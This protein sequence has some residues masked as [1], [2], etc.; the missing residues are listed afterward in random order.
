LNAVIANSDSPDTSLARAYV[1][2]SE[3][4]AVSSLDTVMQ[5]C[6]KAKIIAVKALITNP[7][8]KT[9]KS[10]L[11]ILSVALNNLGFVY[12]H[13]G[14]NSIAL[15]HYYK[16]LKIDKALGDKQG[17]SVGLLNIADIYEQQGDIPKAL[18]YHH[19]SLKTCE[20][21]GNKE[22]IAKN[23]NQLG[24][25]YQNQGDSPKAIEY[26]NKSLKISEATGNKANT[27]AS[28]VSLGSAYYIQGDTNKA[29]EYTYRSL[30][31]IEKIGGKLE[32]SS[33]LNNLSFFYYNQGDIQK[34]L[35]YNNRCLK[36]N[37][38]MG[39]K[40]GVA[41]ALQ[42]IGY[43]ELQTGTNGLIKAKRHLLKALEMAQEIGYPDLISSV[44][45]HLSKVYEAEGKGMKALE[46]Y[47][48]HIQMKD[49]INNETTQK[50]TIR[51]QTQFEFEKAQIV[52]ENEAKEAARVLEEETSRRDNI[53]YSL[54]FLGIL[55][56]F[57]IVISLGFIKVSP[58]IAE[59]IIFFAFLILFEF[60][61]VFTEPY[62]EQYTNG[63]PMYNLLANSVLALL[64]FPLHAILEKLLKKRI[65]KV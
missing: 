45:G 11:S 3:L 35:E 61:L 14:N 38:E 10:L 52:K 1:S 18:E 27:A 30:K 7:E 51:Q 50:A 58:K 62:M 4:L 31:I 19:K 33:T 6:K 29:I 63:E 44:S 24:L 8:S 21:I 60:V 59:G 5:L 46:M 65:V 47:K 39:D 40:E 20:E 28:L 25:I 9:R 12:S 42:N 37:E 64:I 41:R 16:S 57:G 36:L 53:Q 34:A 56:L 15:E 2:L 55:V 49:S 32:L 13:Q 26:Y 43:N 22:D 23:L 17:I 54:I 48:L